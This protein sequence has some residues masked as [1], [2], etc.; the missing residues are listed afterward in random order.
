M[1]DR[2]LPDDAAPSAGEPETEPE[3]DLR[4]L[5]RD[6]RLARECQMLRATRREAWQLLGVNSLEEFNALKAE[7]A[8]EPEPTAEPEREPAQET[9]ASNS[10]GREAALWQLTAR[11]RAVDPAVMYGILV[12][13]VSSVSEDGTPLDADGEPVTAE[14]VRRA[15]PA[16]V[17]P[18]PGVMGGGGG[19]TPAPMPAPPAKPDP[20]EAGVSSQKFYEAHRNE[21]LAAQKGH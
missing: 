11:V 8:A 5:A 17:A 20:V 16:L 9:A 19:R 14:T 3:P 13:A 12:E 4:V 18:T 21:I 7:R 15:L 2:E 10:A 1:D 6:K